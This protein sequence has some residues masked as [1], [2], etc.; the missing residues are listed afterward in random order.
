MVQLEHVP[1]H[2]SIEENFKN[3]DGVMLGG[4]SSC[5]SIRYSLLAELVAAVREIETAKG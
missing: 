3:H 1:W 5:I 2:A 4:F